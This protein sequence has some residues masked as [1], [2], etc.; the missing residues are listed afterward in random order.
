MTF[1]K[2]V[3]RVLFSAWIVTV[4]VS[5]NSQA[6]DARTVGPLQKNPYN[7]QELIVRS[8]TGALNIRH[9]RS[10]Q[11]MSRY[12]PYYGQTFYQAMKT[13]SVNSKIRNT[14]RSI[15]NF[16]HVSQPG[17]LDQIVQRCPPPPNDKN[18]YQQTPLGY[19]R[20]RLFLMGYFY[21]VQQDNGQYAIK[22]AYCNKLY[23][24]SEFKGNSGPRP[25]FVPDNRVINVEHTW[26]Q[27]R[28]T[29]RHSQEAQKSDL[30]HLFPTDS[31]LNAI[32]GNHPFGEVVKDSASLKC[33]QS[34]F[35]VSESI[36]G[37]TFEPPDVHKGHVA[38]A[39]LYFALRYDM[40]I[41]PNQEANLKAWHK[42]YPVDAEELLRNDEIY[43]VQGNR[44][45]FIDHPEL[46]DTIQDF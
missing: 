40:S 44:N 25:N 8:N 19:E 20:A 9:P 42:Q 17:Q 6:F 31:Q 2:S 15:L 23:G 28:F 3:L 24:Q 4:L 27:S 29:G 14:L 5:Q 36:R 37:P 21:L 7:R 10:G 43:K 26:P 32:R 22:E 39:L 38:R 46:V 16:P 12:I 35:G 13:R 30:H 34:R 41:E 1:S 45:P 18:C 33:G 11:Y